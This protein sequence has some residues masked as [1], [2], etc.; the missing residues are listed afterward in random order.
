MSLDLSSIMLTFLLTLSYLETS[1]LEGKIEGFD[2]DF[3]ISFADVA[4]VEGF[5]S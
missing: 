3:S 4:G 1:A 2:D 5:K